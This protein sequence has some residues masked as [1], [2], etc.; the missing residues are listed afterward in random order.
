MEDEDTDLLKQ[1][2]VASNG[3]E[4]SASSATVPADERQPIRFRG[5]AIQ[6]I[7]VCHPAASSVPLSFRS[8]ADLVEKNARKIIPGK[9]LVQTTASLPTPVRIVRANETKCLVT[10][11]PLLGHPPQPRLRSPHQFRTRS[12]SSIPS[13]SESAL[14][15]RYTQSACLFCRTLETPLA[16]LEI[17]R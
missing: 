13:M 9:K 15:Q 3:L 2:S 12:E 6:E 7:E 5:L 10:H 8:L 1:Q 16:L 4:P 11:L 17:R 14:Y